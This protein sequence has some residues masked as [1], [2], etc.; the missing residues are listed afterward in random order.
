[1]DLS[2]TLRPFYFLILSRYRTIKIALIKRIDAA[3][4]L[5]YVADKQCTAC[6]V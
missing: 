4:L 1:M 6:V 5:S 2:N 3:G